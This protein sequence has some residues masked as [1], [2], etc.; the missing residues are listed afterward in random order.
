MSNEPIS[1]AAVQEA[2]KSFGMLFLTIFIPF[3]MGHFISYLYRTVNAV[4][5]NDLATDLYLP[6][7]S[8]GVLKRRLHPQGG[9]PDTVDGDDR[10]LP[11]PGVHLP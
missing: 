9:C 3:G 1:V 4:I 6:A 10:H 2:K 11:Q 8:L 7:E 5:Y